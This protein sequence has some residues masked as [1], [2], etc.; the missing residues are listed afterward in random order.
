MGV[1]VLLQFGRPPAG[2]TILSL[3]KD[4]YTAQ[5]ITDNFS[6][7]VAPGTE[8]IF[9]ES[10][11]A[12]TELFLSFR[13]DKQFF[14]TN[15]VERYFFSFCRIKYSGLFLRENLARVFMNVGG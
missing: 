9:I 1:L 15:A 3:S 10:T 12:F 11:N 7:R 4:V 8:G 2:R 6:G 5:D 13:Y 14:W